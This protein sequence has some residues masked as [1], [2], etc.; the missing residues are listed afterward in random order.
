MTFYLHYQCTDPLEAKL[1]IILLIK[2]FNLN[3]GQVILDDLT[4]YKVISLNFDSHFTI[5]A[6]AGKF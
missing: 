5:K 3:T 2:Y 4:S 6:E 1:R